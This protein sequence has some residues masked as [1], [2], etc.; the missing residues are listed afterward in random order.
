MSNLRIGIVGGGQP[1][2]WGARVHAPAW[3]AL[4]GI[5]ITA[6]C[7]SREET[8][9]EAAKRM[10]IPHA[11][12]DFGEM[13]RAP[14]VDLVCVAVRAGLHEQVVMAAVE[15]KKHVFC[16]W[17]LALDGDQAARM[18]KAVKAAGVTHGVGTQG[19]YSPSLMYARDLV[20]QG[21]IGQPLV[22]AMTMLSPRAVVPRPADKWWVPHVE[23]GGS[24]LIIGCGHATDALRMVIGE[25]DSVCGRVQVLQKET[26][27]EGQDKPTITTSPDTVSYLA[28]L[29][30]GAEGT[31]NFTYFAWHG[32][33]WRLDVY[34]KEGR[35]LLTSKDLA[36]MGPAA[37]TLGKKG[38]KM[39]QMAVPVQYHWITN[40]DLNSNV[41]NVAQEFSRFL[42]TIGKPGA[43]HNNFD[44]AV[45]LHLVLDAIDRSSSSGKWE[46]VTQ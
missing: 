15:A 13:A 3:R 27:V 17:P 9:R 19:R 44:D 2:V 41:Y 6:V 31:V 11:F 20:A 5:E 29:S 22:F 16:E 21:A 7:T 23:E 14:Y 43:F 37:I 4:K 36:Q 30:N 33:G 34:G 32:E 12:W 42:P 24:G 25:I 10:D 35:L 40:V 38:G 18:A 39:E 46:R 8:A 45:A 28:R 26:R 1:T